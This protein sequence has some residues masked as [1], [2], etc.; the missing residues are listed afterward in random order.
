MLNKKKTLLIALLAIILPLGALAGSNFSKKA[1]FIQVGPDEVIDGNYFAA[2]ER[3]EVAGQ[4]NGDVI[5]AGG[6][7]NIT[8][9]VAG[10]ILALGGDVRI[11]GPVQGDIRVLAGTVYL[12]G[13]VG[14]NATIAGGDVRFSDDA[15][16]GSGLV[17]LA[18]NFEQRGSVAKNV[19][20]V[21]GAATF[22]GTVG[23]NVW[24]KAS[25][26]D[27][28]ILFP[29]AKILGDFV[30]SAPTP[31]NI[32]SGAIIGGEVDYKSFKRKAKAGAGFYFMFK[33]SLFIGL[34]FIGLL[35]AW[36]MP[37]KFT[38]VN[39]QITNSFGPTIGW[40]AF[41]LILTPVIIFILF[42]TVIAWPLA[43]V[44]AALYCLSLFASI[45]LIS[46]WLG[47]WILKKLSKRHL[48]GVSL[49][50][51][52]V[53]GLVL[54]IILTSIPFLGFWIKL[55]GLSIG[56]GAMLIVDKKELK[57]YR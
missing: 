15:A 44:L 54:F 51:S 31:A 7:V 56:L 8:G 6:I 47:E 40:G 11:S 27:Q 4:I 37:K 50:W 43:L 42:A 48:R 5:V 33:L 23:E 57:R 22:A 26:P 19:R 21:V 55:V 41:A 46:T 17:I 13:V 35:M 20:G 10:D 36:I 45:I 49:R 52:M 28:L 24:L 1:V 32:I 38:L 29:G 30:Y 39:K 34:L 18:G 3:I 25:E 12:D 2:A 53:L 9:S 14:K 16:I